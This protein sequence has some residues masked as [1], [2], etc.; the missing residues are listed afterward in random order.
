MKKSSIIAIVLSLFLGPIVQ[1]QDRPVEQKQS[2]FIVANATLKIERMMAAGL[3]GDT[4]GDGII[5]LDDP[6]YGATP[7]IEREVYKTESYINQNKAICAQAEN[8]DLC[9][10]G[11]NFSGGFL[12]QQAA[13]KNEGSTKMFV[14]KAT[15]YYDKVLEAYP[16]NKAALSNL[17]KLNQAIKGNSATIA[18]LEELAAK[19]PKNRVGYLVQIGDLYKEEKK[20]ASAC[21]KYQEAYLE[22]PFSEKACG[23]IVA[24]YTEDGHVCTTGWSI[25]EFAA[26][27]QEIDL[28][29]YSEELLRKEMSIAFAKKNYKKAI[30]SMVLWAYVL[31]DNGWLDSKQVARL[32]N[33]LFLEGAP[34]REAARMKRALTELIRVLEI[35]KPGDSRA[36]VFW[37]T[38][39]PEL[40]IS[41]DWKRISPMSVFLK[42]MHA[43]GAKAFLKKD[44]KNAEAHWQI[45]L[46]RALG[47]DNNLYTT[48]ASD[49]AELYNAYPRM[50]PEGQKLNRIVRELFDRKS[51]AYRKVDAKIIRNMHMTLGAIYYNKGIWQNGDYAENAEFQ[52][53]RAVSDRF[54]P[55]VNPRLRKMLGDVYMH[56]DTLNS[57]ER[58]SK[59]ARQKA[60]KAYSASI[61]DYLSLDLLRDA[62]ALHT[63]LS[64][65]YRSEM[66]R[67][68]SDSF[69]ALGSV[70]AWRTQMADPKNELLRNQKPIN[71]YLNDVNKAAE[72]LGGVLPKEFVEVQFFKG[73]SD[74]GSQMSE[75]RKQEQQLLYA[76]ALSQI[77]E[78]KELSSPTDF[79]RI[80]KIKGSLE[81]SVEQ[82]G[83]LKK[84]QMH[85]KADL[86]Y[87]PATSKTGFKAYSISTLDKEILVPDELYELNGTLQ[88]HYKR[89]NTKNLVKLKKQNGKFMVKERG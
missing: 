8:P 10:A 4:D 40:T 87:S 37:D 26:D 64:N 25:R 48:T 17:K 65:K 61:K 20:F 15:E 79:R 43:K 77:K 31:A 52:L 29:N 82:R 21:A 24:M 89:T 41:T 23:G 30:E 18:K 5:N 73:L 14:E 71:T 81:A 6:Q 1:G 13:L 16:D 78:V 67:A 83:Q 45:I 32:S 22:D 68:R 53:S 7:N 47:Y 84:T 76:N 38:Y 51:E 55:I 34:S 54:G 58:K 49:M 74:L 62:S 66:G 59:E 72:E 86:S 57:D 46:D 28:P 80:N 60:M 35:E 44:F 69:V 56:I 12:F 39:S 70:I 27:C 19:Y 75:D 36:L 88:E 42:I 33:Q 2:K 63:D 11:L 9:I 3:I 85:G 50:D